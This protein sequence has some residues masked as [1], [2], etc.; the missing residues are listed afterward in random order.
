MNNC[1]IS[2]YTCTSAR[3]NH[4][5]KEPQLLSDT[6]DLLTQMLLL[7]FE[8]VNPQLG[9]CHNGHLEYVQYN[10]ELYGT[11]HLLN[12]L[13]LLF[14]FFY[15]SVSFFHFFF[16]FMVN[17]KQEDK[18]QQEG[19]ITSCMLWKIVRYEPTLV[20]LTTSFSTLE[21]WSMFAMTSR[22]LRSSSAHSCGR[23]EWEHAL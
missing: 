7:G 23:I 10:H 2:W 13:P 22:T 16:Y 18:E 21:T 15:C 3:K 6:F 12:F 19:K 11:P 5:E 14:D 17:L 20:I 4:D 9:L 1:C 8:I